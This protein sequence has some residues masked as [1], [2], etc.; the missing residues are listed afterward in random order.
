[1]CVCVYMQ[2]YIYIYMYVCIHI[3]VFPK[4]RGPFSE[5]SYD[6]DQSMLGSCFGAPF[7]DALI[8]VYMYVSACPSV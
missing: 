3:W 5:F 8:Y 2:V 1:M 7:M 6:K 4:V